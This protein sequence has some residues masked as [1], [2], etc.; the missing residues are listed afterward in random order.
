YLSLNRRVRNRTHGGVGARA[1]NR[2][3]YPMSGAIWIT[4]FAV[5][6]VSCLLIVERIGASSMRYC[7]VRPDNSC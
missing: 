7:L 1:G 2:P 5:M 3:G 4:A 6:T